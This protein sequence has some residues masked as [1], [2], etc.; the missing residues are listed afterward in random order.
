MDTTILRYR[1]VMDATIL[2]Y[3]RTIDTAHELFSSWAP[4]PC[5]HG[6]NLG[7]LGAHELVF[8]E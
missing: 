4:S 1:L 2:R 6:L 5:M 7:G 8:N 3:R